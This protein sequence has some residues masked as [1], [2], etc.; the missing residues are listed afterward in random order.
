LKYSLLFL[1]FI[2]SVFSCDSTIDK[3]KPAAL[4]ITPVYN[5]ASPGNDIRNSIINT[6]NIGKI[7]KVTLNPNDFL[8]DLIDT[9]IDLDSHDEQILIVKDN[10][11]NNSSVRVLVADFDNIMNSYSVSWEGVTGSDNIRSLSISLKDITG[12]HNLEIVVSGTDL[13]GKETLN[14]YRRTPSQDGIVIYF[15]EILNLIAD[16]NIEIKE[17]QRTQAYQTGI[18]GGMSFPVIVTTSDNESDNILDLIQTTYFWRNQESVYKLIS[19]DKIKGEE[20]ENS[21]LRELYRSDRNFFKS[22]LNGPWMLSNSDN[23]L[24]YHNPVVYF[25]NEKKQIIF[26]NNDFLEIYLW[27]SSSKTLS[28]T[29]QI[30]CKNDLV[31][32]LDVTI[33]V[34]VLDM[35]TINIKFRD[36]SIRTNRN[37]DNQAWTGNYFMLNPD[38]QKNIIEDFRSVSKDDEIPVLSGYYRS[39]IGDEFSFNLP[40]F[41]LKTENDILNGGFY[42]FDNGLKIAEF[43]ILDKNNLVKYI[44]TYK[45]DYFEEINEIEIIRTLILIPGKLTIKGFLESGEQFSRFIQIEQ[46][47]RNPSDN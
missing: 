35:N 20:I 27:E 5:S 33:S 26:S 41:T 32:F 2:I 29:L 19:T 6:D 11:S 31:P 10:S 4:E 43:K 42:L 30:T 14:I 28:N 3:E 34:R 36:N 38:I 25:D 13:D 21:K 22:Y 24:S 47:E 46:I 8:I 9:N 12:D 17:Q 15:S 7:P 1:I 16:G 44:L 40:N 39:D 23:N 18:S 37:T 45:Y